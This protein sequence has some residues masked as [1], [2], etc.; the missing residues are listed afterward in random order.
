MTLLPLFSLPPARPTGQFFVL[1]GV[2][3]MVTCAV[4]LRLNS[5][6]KLAVLLLA[7]AANCCLIQLAFNTLSQDTLHRSVAA[8][9]VSQLSV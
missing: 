8:K 6:L 2:I 3:A 1:S 4:F 9:G 5:Q 7:V